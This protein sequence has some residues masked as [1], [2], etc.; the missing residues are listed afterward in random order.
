[1]SLILPVINLSLVY[2]LFIIFVVAV[3]IL[4]IIFLYII[5]SNLSG[6][7]KGHSLSSEEIQQAAYEEAMRVLDQARVKSIKIIYDSQNKAEKFAKDINSLDEQAKARLL[8]RIESLYESQEKS[9]AQLGKDLSQ[10]YQ[11]A[12][13]VEKKENIKTIAATTEIIKKEVLSNIDDF[14]DAIRKETVGGQLEVEERLKK[15]YEEVE[16]QIQDYKWKKIKSLNERIMQIIA[17][18]AEQVFSK[19]VD[20][21]DQE[22]VVLEMLE[23][24]I[25]KLNTK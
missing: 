1:M 20:F 8:N 21:K 6:W 14:K 4:I 22:K 9:L 19:K 15:S 3:E 10:S 5:R 16:A 11:E 25:S 7:G 12:I 24:G 23:E 2:V 17:D 18:I 13:E